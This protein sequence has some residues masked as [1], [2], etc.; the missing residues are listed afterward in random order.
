MDDAVPMDDYERANLREGLLVLRALGLDTGDWL[1]QLL[2][3]VRVPEG[4]VPNVDQDTQVGRAVRHLKAK[5]TQP[6][7][8]TVSKLWVRGDDKV[9]RQIS[10][11][12]Q[13]TVMFEALDS[14]DFFGQERER[15]TVVASAPAARDFKLL[16]PEGE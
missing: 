4:K 8:E 5:W 16:V 2:H 11:T 10:F 7:A 15:V 3:K 1:G 13:P 9:F 6:S 14:T 12:D